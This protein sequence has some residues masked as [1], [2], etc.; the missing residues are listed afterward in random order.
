M[1]IVTDGVYALRRIYHRFGV[2]AYEPGNFWIE[3]GLSQLRA[4]L[5][6]ARNI[7]PT[8]TSDAAK[9]KRKISSYK[10]FDCLEFLIKVGIETPKNP[11]YNKANSIQCVVTPDFKEYAEYKANA[12]ESIGAQ[13]AWPLL[14]R[15]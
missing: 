3:K 8:D 7:L 13:A 4:I 11:Q 14:K 15:F 1:L 9:E 12:E 10:D 5:E 6:S 2:K